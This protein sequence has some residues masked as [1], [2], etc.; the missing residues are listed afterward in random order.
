MDGNLAPI[1]TQFTFFNPW[2][3]R[4]N[5]RKVFAVLV[6]RAE[7]CDPFGAFA[8]SPELTLCL[9]TFPFSLSFSLS[10]ATTSPTATIR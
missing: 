7:S 6:D 3:A 10:F 5:E 9:L 1:N 8:F 2:S 4:G